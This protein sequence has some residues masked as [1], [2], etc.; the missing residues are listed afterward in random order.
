MRYWGPRK[1][2]MGKVI[3]QKDKRGRIEKEEDKE[4]IERAPWKERKYGE[5]NETA[6]G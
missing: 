6:K 2:N 4:G 1:G 5:E 3:R